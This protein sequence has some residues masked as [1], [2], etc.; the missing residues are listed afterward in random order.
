[1]LRRPPL[2]NGMTSAP[3]CIVC[4]LHLFSLFPNPLQFQ[5]FEATFYSNHMGANDD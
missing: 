1:M 2:K 5:G 3:V 4:Q